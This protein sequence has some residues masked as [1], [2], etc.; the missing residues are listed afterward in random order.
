MK[1]VGKIFKIILITFLVIMLAFVIFQKVTKSKIAIGNIYIF[2]VA[3]ESM[4]PEYKVGDIIVVKKE[5]PSK[6]EVGDDV[7]YLGKAS[8]V[9]NLRITHRVIN[10]RKDN[11]KY[12]FTTKGIANDVEDPEINE[13]DLFGKVSYHTIFFSFIG[14]LM[15]NVVVYYFAF[16]LV[17]AIFSYDFIKS[18]FFKKEESDEEDESDEKEK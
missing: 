16:I 14:R 17:A 1:T 8:S 3:T 10:K 6:I 15:T 9:Q 2:Q 18:T 11:D 4:T 12:Y 13:D 5:D 7:T